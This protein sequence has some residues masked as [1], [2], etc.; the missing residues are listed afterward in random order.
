[1]GKVLTKYTSRSVIEFFPQRFRI[2]KNVYKF[3]KFS[4]L[5][6][7]SQYGILQYIMGNALDLTQLSEKET[8][9]SN[10]QN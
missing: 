1:M 9:F 10:Y 2:L 6:S 3:S 5:S 7:I 8:N 4:A